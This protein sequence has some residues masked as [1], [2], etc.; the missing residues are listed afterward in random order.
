M[1]L[2]REIKQ[3]AL[4]EGFNKV[5]IVGASALEDEGRRIKRWLALGYHGDM[6]WMSRDVE[7]RITPVE[8]FPQARSVI[9][10]ALNYFTPHQHQQSPTTGKVSRYAWGDDYHDVVKTKLSSLLAWIR[11]Q[12]PQ[13]EG[14]I[15]VDIQPTMDKAWAVRAGL[16]WLGKHSNVITQEYGSWVFIGELF[17]NLELEH[18][19]ERV[20]DHCGTCTLC[21]DACPTAAITEPYV[22]DSNKC[23]SYATIELRT[24]ELPDQMDLDGW[25][26]GCDVCQDVCPWNR[27]EESTTEERFAPRPGNVNAELSEI[28]ELTPETYAARFRGSA[29]KRAKLSGL[30]RNAR[31]I[32]V[33]P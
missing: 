9:V 14:K 8:I 24:P 2:A 13:T 25:L 19:D 33:R 32:R 20:E 4:F 5:G 17:L 29:M 15:C 10:V 12:D 16:G 3:R 30:Q 23:I 1:I 6:S 18:D 7:K 11:Q 31:R 26:Y 27:F 28:L 21:I 22:V